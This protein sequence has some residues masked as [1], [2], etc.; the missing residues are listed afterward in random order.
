MS[1]M[2]ILPISKMTNVSCIIWI[3]AYEQ[4]YDGADEITHI[5]PERLFDRDYLLARSQQNHFF[6]PMKQFHAGH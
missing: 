5:P 4:S 3:G 2:L 6:L 1:A